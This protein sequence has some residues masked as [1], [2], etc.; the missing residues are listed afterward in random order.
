MP[1]LGRG[2]PA[3]SAKVTASRDYFSD[4]GGRSLRK[5][6]ER[7]DLGY[8]NFTFEKGYP[9]ES[10]YATTHGILK[11]L[12]DGERTYLFPPAKNLEW[13]RPVTALG[14][15]GINEGVAGRTLTQPLDPARPGELSRSDFFSFGW[16]WLTITGD[17]PAG[18]LI[19][20]CGEFKQGRQWW[21]VATDGLYQSEDGGSTLK[22][23]LETNG[24]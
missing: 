17:R 16:N 14:Y 15:S 22:K 1:L 21:L 8:F 9:S 23:V 12:Y 13:L 2:Q 4:D 6:S 5:T 10:P 18:G 3:I 19:S 7:T 11:S 20:V 24:R